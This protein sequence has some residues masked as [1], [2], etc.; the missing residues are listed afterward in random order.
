[1]AEELIQAEDARQRVEK[2]VEDKLTKTAIRD[3]SRAIC[4]K[5]DEGLR[6]VQIFAPF[7]GNSKKNQ[8]RQAVWTRAARALLTGAGYEVQ[9]SRSGDGAF[10]I[11]RW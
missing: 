10:L 5:S 4:K 9:A 6:E 2:S 7:D 3:L 11:V 8:E 1:M